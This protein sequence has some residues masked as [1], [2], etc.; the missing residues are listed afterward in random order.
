MDQLQKNRNHPAAKQQAFL[1]LKSNEERIDS[2]TSQLDYLQKNILI[3]R[4]LMTRE[5]PRVREKMSKY[6][7]DYIGVMN[8]SLKKLDCP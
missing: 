5:Y 3:M 1:Q 6:K 2:V 4:D 8:D 7:L